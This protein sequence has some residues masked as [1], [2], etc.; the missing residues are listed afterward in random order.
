MKKL[1]I[2]TLFLIISFLS[3][4]QK[5][6][7][8]GFEH[9]ELISFRNTTSDSVLN[10]PDLVNDVNNTK[11]T[12]VIDLDNKT[13]RCYV[14]DEFLNSCSLSIIQNDDDAIIV[15]LIDGVNDCGIIIRDQNKFPSCLVYW[16]QVGMTSVRKINKFDISKL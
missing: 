5:F 13:C 12:F 16:N 10:N 3:F 4:S 8:E 2:C 1:F 9:Q 15:K 11:L 14:L 7:I 6:V